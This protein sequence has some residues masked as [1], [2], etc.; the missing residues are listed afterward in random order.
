MPQ[1]KVPLPLLVYKRDVEE[2]PEEA[3]AL[4]FDM[5]PTV[6]GAYVKRPCVRSFCNLGTSTGI[7]GLY[8]SED[9]SYVVVVSGGSIFKV[10]SRDGVF[11]DVTGDSLTSGTPVMFD[12]D[13]TYITMTNGANIVGYNNAGASANIL[14]AGAAPTDATHNAYLDGY[15]LATSTSNNNWQF[16]DPTDITAWDAGDV[17]AADMQPDNLIALFVKDSDISLFGTSS[18][19]VR[20]NDGY[21]PFVRKDHLCSSIGVGATYSIQWYNGTYIFLNENRKVVVASGRAV[22]EVSQPIDED[23]RKL[24]SIGDAIS[25]LIEIGNWVLYV[26]TFVASNRTFVL[27]LSNMTWAEWGKWDSSDGQWDRY[28]Y[29][30]HCYAKAWDMN[31]VGGSNDGMLYELSFDYNTDD[32]DEVRS[33]LRTA[34]ITRGTY[35]NKRSHR[36]V[37]RLQRAQGD[38]TADDGRPGGVD[39]PVFAVRFNDDNQGWSEEIYVSLGRIGEKGMLEGELTGLGMYKSRQY[40]FIHTDN[41]EFSLVSVQEDYEVMSH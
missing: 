33:V 26:L 20:F 39:E 38:G 1:E 23:L 22:Q 27:N 32:G 41:S 10:T 12:S 11:T 8:W 16:S 15:N 29:Q 21:A 37:F 5:I 2:L 31:I 28:Y 4:V 35:N 7:D 40:E 18:V 25:S 13:G 3:G 30:S 6:F 19:E 34:P 17:Y 14:G 36:L 24:V 9:Y